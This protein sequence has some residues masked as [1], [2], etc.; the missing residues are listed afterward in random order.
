MNKQAFKKALPGAASTSIKGRPLR[1][2][3]V[4]AAREGCG[5]GGHFSLLNSAR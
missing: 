1:V 4:M 3:I 2:G 5:A